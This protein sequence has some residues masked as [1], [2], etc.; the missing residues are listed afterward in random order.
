[1]FLVNFIIFFK[2]IGR[3]HIYNLIG[4]EENRTQKLVKN[5]NGIY[6]H[7]I[8]N[9]KSEYLNMTPKAHCLVESI[10]LCC[11]LITDQILLWEQFFDMMVS[12]SRL[13]FVYVPRMWFIGFGFMFDLFVSSGARKTWTVWFCLLLQNSL[14]FRL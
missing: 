13:W 10:K 8:K 3:F 7:S 4:T 5:L 6:E 12:I 2:K 9:L 11:W 14:T 1:M